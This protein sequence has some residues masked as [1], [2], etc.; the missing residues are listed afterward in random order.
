MCIINI[1]A[2]LLSNSCVTGGMR[3]CVL[4][5]EPKMQTCVVKEREVCERK[6]ER[7]ADYVAQSHGTLCSP[8]LFLSS[9]DSE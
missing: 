3:W 8:A 1:H 5:P 4:V 7:E 6:S 9:L 2:Y